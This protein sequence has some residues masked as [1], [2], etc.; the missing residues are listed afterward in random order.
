M[1]APGSTEAVSGWSSAQRR[2]S[3]RHR[4]M[5][6]NSRALVP[7]WHVCLSRAL[8]AGASTAAPAPESPHALRLDSLQPH[9]T[10]YP[11]VLPVL[12]TTKVV[13]GWHRAFRRYQEVPL[14]NVR[15]RK[16]GLL[17]GR[18][19]AQQGNAQGGSRRPRSRARRAATRPGAARSERARR[20]PAAPL[21]QSSTVPIRPVPACA[22]S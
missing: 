1:H 12:A 21:R 11:S 19:C 22:D 17:K 2:S 5:S 20:P 14:T 15:C 18:A 4:C 3:L 13:R 6:G 7:G 10:K 16:R 9:I 8:L